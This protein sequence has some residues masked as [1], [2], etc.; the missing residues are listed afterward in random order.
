MNV[1]GD[2]EMELLDVVYIFASEIGV[3]PEFQFLD[4]RPGDQYRTRGDA[5]KARELLEWAP[6]TPLELGLRAQARSVVERLKFD[7]RVH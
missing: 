1:C 6:S 5:S 7:S 2:Q 4:P 3:T